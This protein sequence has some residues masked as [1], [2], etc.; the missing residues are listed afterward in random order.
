MT[1]STPDDTYDAE[2]WLRSL[3][4]PARPEPKP[5]PADL[6]QG[7]RG[8]AGPV[9]ARSMDAWL[10]A[11]ATNDPRAYNENPVAEVTP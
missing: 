10:R 4:R 5:G 11:K 3:A 8:P 7:D 9:R 6:K 2:A 1:S